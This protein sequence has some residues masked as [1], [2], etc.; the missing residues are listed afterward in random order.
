MK[1]FTLVFFLMTLVDFFYARW[2][3]HAA[4]REAFASAGYAFILIVCSAHV[5]RAYVD[6]KTLIW[7]AA[8]GAFAGTWLAVSF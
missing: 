8:L 6:D 1:R 5:T 4:A 3:I 7:A 2:A